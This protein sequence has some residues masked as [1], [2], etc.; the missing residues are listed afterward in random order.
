MQPFHTAGDCPQWVESRLSPL[1]VTP[2][3]TRGPAS[4]CSA[5]V[6]FGWK[7]TLTQQ[8]DVVCCCGDAPALLHLINKDLEPSVHGGNFLR[9]D[10]VAVLDAEIAVPQ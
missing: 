4:L 9:R 6:R 10:G 5:N 7:R 8:L 1:P 2:G 3:L